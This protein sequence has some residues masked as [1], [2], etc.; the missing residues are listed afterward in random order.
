MSYD[1]SAKVVILGDSGTGKSSLLVAFTDPGKFSTRH[2]VSLPPRLRSDLRAPCT[3]RARCL[4]AVCPPAACPPVHTAAARCLPRPLQVTIGVEFGSKHITLPSAHVVKLQLWD[5]A[6]QEAFRSIVRTY[7]RGTAA[8]L[9]LFDVSRRASFNSVG[10]WLR[11]LREH[12]SVPSVRVLLVGNKADL[13]ESQREVGYE[14]ANSFAALHGLEYLETSARTG[15]NVDVAFKGVAQ[16]LLSEVLA[17]RLDP[18]AIPTQGVKLGHSAAARAHAD[19]IRVR[20]VAAAHAVTP[21][22]G[23]CLIS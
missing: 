20:K 7:Y 12:C 14:E 16:T 21:N 13:P 5:T 2:D 15:R 4:H 17:G 10:S 6:G 22:G 8:A 18:T 9:I 19:G 3:L 1:Y 23:C 11:E